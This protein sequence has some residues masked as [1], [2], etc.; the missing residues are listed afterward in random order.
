MKPL[1]Q[2]LKSRFLQFFDRF[3]KLNRREFGKAGEAIAYRYLKRRGY[4]VLE[5]NYRTRLG[6]IDIVAEDGDVL[7]FVEVKMK[8]SDAYGLPEEAIN[9]KKIRKLTRLAQLYIKHKNLYNKKARFD[10]VSILY[11]GVFRRK[12][13]KL[14]KNA[15]DTEE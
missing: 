14:I 7:V 2:H 8:R 12:S 10:V 1:L 3:A 11:G 5:K 15:F 6:E 13:I 4:A 9:S